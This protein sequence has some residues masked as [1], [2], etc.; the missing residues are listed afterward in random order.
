MERSIFSAG[1]DALLE[2]VAR[3]DATRR[4]EEDRALERALIDERRASQNR[5]FG[6]RERQLTS[7]DEDRDERRR[8]QE[9]A[10]QRE[11]SEAA[12]V[13]AA[14][15]AR[16][17]ALDRYTEAVRANDEQAMKIT[18]LE[19]LNLG[20]KTLPDAPKP[21]PFTLSPGQARFGPDGKRIASV[22]PRPDAVPAGMKDDPALPLGTKRWIE[23]LAQ[24]PGMTIEDARKWLSNGW[25]GQLQSHPRALLPKAVDYLNSMFPSEGGLRTPLVPPV[26]DEDAIA[27]LEKRKIPVSP[28]SIAEA[29]RALAGGR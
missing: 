21:A 23:E 2:G 27:E 16:A 6:L 13:Q 19:L 4:M 18:G 7:L 26:S 10:A 11:Q 3:R 5:D 25:Q 15:A 9:A 24:T 20:G 1:R 8:L 22:A 14:A 17:A 28:E 12:S 29:K